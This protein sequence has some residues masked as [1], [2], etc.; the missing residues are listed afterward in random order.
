M[1]NVACIQSTP[2][3]S[4]AP[5]NALLGEM[6]Q[7]KQ[8]VHDVTA[9]FASVQA[10]Q[11]G[12]TTGLNQVKEQITAEQRGRE[13]ALQALHK[14]VGEQYRALELQ[15]QQA[16]ALLRAQ[17]ENTVQTVQQAWEAKME[18]LLKQHADAQGSVP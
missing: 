12:V 11:D 4:Q 18:R 16:V 10:L 13:N 9:V 2:A 7:V 15:S 5:V 14:L 3:C 8:Q 1:A 17:V 6:Q